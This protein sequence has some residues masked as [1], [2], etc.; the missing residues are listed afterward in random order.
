VDIACVVVNKVWPTLT[1]GR[2]MIAMN[3]LIVIAS[4]LASDAL[5]S[6][7]TLLSIFV[8]GKAVDV[9][10]GWGVAKGGDS[11]EQPLPVK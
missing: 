2:M 10:S 9:C 6:L 3:A 5:H 4:W 7:Y 1:I 8:A 11:K